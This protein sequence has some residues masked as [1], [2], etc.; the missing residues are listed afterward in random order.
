MA[1]TITKFRELWNQM[2]TSQRLIFLSLS[3]A[4]LV[5]LLLFFTWLGR[6][7]YTLL[8]SNLSTQDSA[9]VIELLQKKNVE[10]RVTNGG[11]GIM[12]QASRLG[13]MKVVLAGEGLPTGG[14]TG[15]ELFDNQGIGVS[16]FTQ[17][18]NFRR[19]LEGELA[20]SIGTLNGVEKA[21]VHLVIPKPA[22]FKEDRQEPSASVVLNLA[23]PGA[24]RADQVQAVQRLVASSVEGLTSEQVTILDSFGTLL[25]R[26][27]GGEVAGLSSAQLE[28]KQEV[29]IY[30]A[31]KAQGT[32]ESVLGA[33]AALVRVNAELD[34]EQVERTR[35][36]VDPEFAV[37]LSEQRDQTTRENDGENTESSTVNYEF[38]R[39]V[40]NIIGSTG[41]VKKLSVA[42]LI[43]GTY[44]EEEGASEYVP[45][46]P[47]E[48]EG[49]RKVVEN[50]VGLESERGDKIEVL[51][52][53]FSDT[54]LPEGGGG[55]MGG[56]IMQKLP[57]LT[58]RLL[59]IAAL[60]FLLA[61]LRKMGGQLADSV[62]R[63]IPTSAGSGAEGVAGGSRNSVDA[64]DLVGQ[65]TLS[66]AERQ[67]KM[68]EQA[69]ALAMEKPEDVAQLVKTWMQ[70]KD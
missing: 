2:G 14:I 18:L 68:E 35:E 11:S 21:R 52:V 16:E 39:M 69:K 27:F 3:G 57:G 23:R 48:L 49:Y 41:T 34:F 64:E 70:A 7:D 67:M 45:R 55:F 17:N 24:L 28:L 25:T 31:R 42:V 66:Q 62:S 12:V 65:D 61:T 47:Q 9:R 56:G 5:T 58:N 54:S 6:E 10:Y 46:S 53:R 19:A 1:D 8:Y 13:E 51:N 50:I 44:T 63:A 38:N 15:Y 40:E 32:L 26:E 22:L 29:E 30:L 36:V 37:V 60:L 43:D 20:R 33:G 4:I 59:F